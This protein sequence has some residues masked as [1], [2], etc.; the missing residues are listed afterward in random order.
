MGVLDMFS[1]EGKT[2]LVTG[3]AGLYGRQ[4]VRAVAEAGAKTYVASRGIEAL[5]AVAAEFRG[6]GLD[7]TAFQYDQGEEASILALRDTILGKAGNG[8][9]LVAGRFAGQQ[10]DLL[11]LHIE[12]L[13]EKLNESLVG[14]AF[15]RRRLQSDFDSVPVEPQNLIFRCARRHANG[16]DNPVAG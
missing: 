12:L 6:E 14:P 16:K 9:P 15:D 7:V 10:N 8:D 1:L 13:T 3:G 11:L 2:A 5:E 4:I